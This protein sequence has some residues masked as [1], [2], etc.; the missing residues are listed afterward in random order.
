MA[1]LV[2]NPLPPIVP[3]ACAATVLVVAPITGTHIG[4]PTRLI[5]Q[6]PTPAALTAYVE[7]A[8]GVY[9]ATVAAAVPVKEVLLVGIRV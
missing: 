3:N 4:I 8:A 1:P 6:P 5:A 9:I 2:L 7:P